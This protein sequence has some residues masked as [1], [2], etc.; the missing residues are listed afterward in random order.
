MKKKQVFLSYEKKI[1]DYW[2]I[3]HVEAFSQ[4]E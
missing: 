1:S 4:S 2:L 3:I